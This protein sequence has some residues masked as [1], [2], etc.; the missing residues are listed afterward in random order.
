MVVLNTELL[1]ICNTNLTG[2]LVFLFARFGNHTSLTDNKEIK[3]S[4]GPVYIGTKNTGK[5]AQQA[6]DMKDV[7]QMHYSQEIEEKF[8]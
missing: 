8:R 5:L 2:C 3:N 4:T 6:K 1:F 7:L